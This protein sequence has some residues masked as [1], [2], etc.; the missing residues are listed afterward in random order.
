MVQKIRFWRLRKS[1]A[2]VALRIKIP[3]GGSKS[4]RLTIFERN[5]PVMAAL[6]CGGVSGW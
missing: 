5:R 3:I 6:H 4:G 2:P 1:I